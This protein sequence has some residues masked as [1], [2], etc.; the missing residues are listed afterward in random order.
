[1][2]TREPGGGGRV[3]EE[4]RG[5]LLHGEEMASETE[6][7]LFFAARAEHVSTLIR[8]ALAQGKVVLCDRY[9]DST[10]AYQGHGLG[11]DQTAIRSLHRFATGDL[12]PDRTIVLDLPPEIGL[13]RQ[14]DANR[15]E[16]RGLEFARKVRNGFLALAA[17]HPDRIKVVDASG[18]VEKVAERVWSTLTG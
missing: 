2:L 10:L 8:P 17:E 4:I 18:S 5:L 16:E 14:G 1:V 3:A 12:W 11:I 7:L 9:T 13:R 6:I 15:M